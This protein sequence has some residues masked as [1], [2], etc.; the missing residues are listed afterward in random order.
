MTHFGISQDVALAAEILLN[1]GVIGMP[2]ETVYG[3]AALALNEDAV[4]RIFDTKGRPR[5]HPLIVHLG[6][7]TDFREWG[8]FN[9]HAMS[10]AKTFWPGPLTLLVPRTALVPDWVTGGRDSVAIRVPSHPMAQDLLNR[11]ESG[12]VAPSANKFGKVSPTSPQHVLD[13]LGDDVDIVLDGGICAVG[14][15][16]TI[17]E[18]TD[19]F[20]VL[21]PGQITSEAIRQCV[22]TS[23][24]GSS[25]ISRAPGMLASHYAPTARV[26]LVDSIQQANESFA[27]LS[28]DKKVRI[29]HF[30]NVNSYAES[31]Y[32]ELRKSDH[33]EYEIVIAVRAPSSGLGIAIN[34]RLSKAAAE[35]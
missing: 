34:D 15:E 33:Q 9:E 17:V 12:V 6:P 16:S 27:E 26:L 29:L 24:E 20:Q 14:L 7:S 19:V 18:C 2:T 8:H 32:D 10:L 4:H 31:L 25:G 1:G 21:R 35:R 11:V 30:D 3:L 5:N 13:D 23:P 22:G 28:T